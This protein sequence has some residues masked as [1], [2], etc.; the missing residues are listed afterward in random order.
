MKKTLFIVTLFS[1]F[2][3]TAAQ[4]NLFR[5]YGSEYGL[6]N[7][8]LYSLNQDNSGYLW[9][10]TGEGLYR[11]NGYECDIFT[12]Q[13]ILAE[14]FVTTTF[15]DLS[16][17]LWV[18]HM[19]GGITRID[20]HRF[21]ILV[22]SSAFNS[23]ITDISESDSSTIWGTTQNEGIILFDNSDKFRE[24]SVDLGNELIFCMKHLRDNNFLL[25]TD[26]NLY[27]SEY[28]PETGTLKINNRIKDLPVSKVSM[29]IKEKSNSFLIL[30]QDEGIFNLKI[31]DDN[32]GFK[33]NTIDN[34]ES[35]RLDNLQGGLLVDNNTLWI[36]TMG[37][38]IIKYLREDSG[39]FSY[40]GAINS[41]NGLP[42]NNVKYLFKD[43]EENIWFGMFGEGLIRYID[44]NLKFFSYEDITETNNIY[45]IAP[46][47]KNIWIGTENNLIKL[48]HNYGS[49]L[50]SIELPVQ[51]KGLI[52]NSIYECKDG[53][54]Y[55]GYDKTGITVFNP[56]NKSFKNVRLSGDDLE[57]SVNNIT[58]DSEFLWISTK[59]G[60]CKYSLKTGQKIWFNTRNGLPH[61]NIT[62]LF[63]DS[64]D[65]VLVG[66]YCKNIF[67]IDIDNTIKPDPKLSLN[68][69]NS[70]I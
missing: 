20:N 53:L 12:D 39:L 41:D 62:T 70:V 19:S 10:G 34:N 3:L 27:I 47:G 7:S 28:I 11:F 52:I 15:K 6:N 60:A 26:E 37:N 2:L 30:T 48:D 65:R 17:R 61:N 18:G 4:D 40:N 38:G 22:E 57:N 33:L 29:I 25:G 35:G 23:S 24:I 54:V 14:N 31:E 50:E 45:S 46:S 67:Y 51:N 55:L 43:R 63:I 64:K 16:G 44:D 21:D 58:G 66:T 5:Q 8:F 13:D 32:V 68:G 49:V 42:S 9:I 56:L 36:N 69:L 1:I 59:K